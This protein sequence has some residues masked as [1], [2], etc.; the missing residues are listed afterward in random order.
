MS[1]PGYAPTFKERKSFEIRKRNALEILQTHPDKIP[2]II[3]R[4][5]NERHLP[6]IDRCK[7]LVPNHVTIGD[8]MQIIRRRLNL[9]HEQ[10][11]FLMINEKS[12]FSISTPISSVYLNE[13][14]DDGFLYIVYTSQPA[15]G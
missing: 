14:D 15:F 2:I 4:Y 9:H 7:F 5:E 1:L 12:I 13:R 8:L 3:E 6:L 11:F 10:S